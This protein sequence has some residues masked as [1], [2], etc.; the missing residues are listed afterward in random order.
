MPKRHRRKPAM[1][2]KDIVSKQLPRRILVD[3]A[4]YLLDIPLREAELMETEQQRIEDRRS[5]LTAR[6]VDASGE[7]YILHL[8]IQDANRKPMPDRMLRYLTDIR[9]AHPGE[10]VH[11][12]LLYIGRE[13]L[14][15]ANGIDTHQL[16]Y[17]YPIIDM[18]R[19][20]YAQLLVQNS[21]DAVVL[22]ILA[23][24]KGQSPEQVVRDLLE[25]LIQ[26]HRRIGAN[27]TRVS[28]HA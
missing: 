19:V 7:R 26:T 21:A 12:Y 27:A 5:D 13:P 8:E 10:M 11:Q 14:N 24:F 16:H 17:R 22:A 15:M 28:H 25:C 4:Q 6:V 2:P 18:H 3:I 20:D 1:P 9:L 23:D